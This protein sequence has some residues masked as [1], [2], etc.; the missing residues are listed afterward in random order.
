MRGLSHQPL[1]ILW[2]LTDPGV[3]S[4]PSVVNNSSNYKALSIQ[5]TPVNISKRP[6][7][8]AVA[9]FLRRSY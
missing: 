6:A 5:R 7:E 4:Y 9:V 1:S 8:F 2:D 3:I